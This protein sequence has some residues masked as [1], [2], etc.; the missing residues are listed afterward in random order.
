MSSRS[1]SKEGYFQKEI[2][3]ALDVADEKPEGTI[4]VI[5]LK[6]EDCD[7]PRRLI[8]WQWVNYFEGQ[9]FSRL[10]LA[11]RER[12]KELELSIIPGDGPLNTV[13]K[14]IQEDSGRILYRSAD[15]R[16]LL[17]Q[18]RNGR[19]IEKDIEKLPSKTVV[20]ISFEALDETL[21]A[22]KTESR[23]AE[24]KRMILKFIGIGESFHEWQE[25]N[26]KI[27][28]FRNVDK[29]NNKEVIMQR[30]PVSSSNISAIGYEKQSQILEISFLNGSIYQYYDF[31][32]HLYSGLMNASSHG[33]YLNAYIKQGGFSYK[34]IH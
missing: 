12:A 11:L 6:L 7:V 10:I 33:R 32:E 22:F 2:K 19:I 4:F 1:I 15:L 13:R 14:P 24:E 25:K 23:K 20:G 34:Q 28:C 8:K 21:S 26:N 5:P 17:Q 30:I 27:H 16:N 3:F 31:P 29:S 18:V 9:G